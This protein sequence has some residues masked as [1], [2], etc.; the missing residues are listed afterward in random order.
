MGNVR[1]YLILETYLSNKGL[2]YGEVDEL[3]VRRGKVEWNKENR[4]TGWTDVELSEKDRA[5]A[6]RSWSVTQN[7]SLISP[8]PLY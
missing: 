5:E 3:L 8:I 7:C 4:F 1:V 2:R 6:Q